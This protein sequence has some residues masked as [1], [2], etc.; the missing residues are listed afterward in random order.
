MRFP[1]GYWGGL[2]ANSWTRLACRGYARGFYFKLHGT[3]L[4]Y[5]LILLFV[6][7]VRAVCMQ[8]T[9]VGGFP[10]PKDLPNRMRKSWP[11][12]LMGLQRW[13]RK[14]SRKLSLSYE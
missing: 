10:V 2:W 9:K 3:D 5:C 6:F 7:A 12:S 11:S 1:E 14:P 13:V 4:K 8:M